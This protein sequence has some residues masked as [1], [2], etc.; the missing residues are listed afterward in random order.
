MGSDSW[1][2]YSIEKYATGFMSGTFRLAQVSV[3]PM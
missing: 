3:L 2:A 1:Y